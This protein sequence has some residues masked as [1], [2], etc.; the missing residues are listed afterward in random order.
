M[1][2][3]STAARLQE[4]LAGARLT[5]SISVLAELGIPDLLSTGPRSSEDLAT[6]SHTD[7]DALYR[8][9]RTLAAA[10]VLHEGD[11]HEFAL[12]E[13][14]DLLRT[15]APASLRDQAL[16]IFS[17]LF[18][19]AW[20]N[21]GHSIRTGENAFRALHGEDVWAWQARNP[22]DEARFNR[23]MAGVTAGVASGVAEAYDFG[24][25]R[26]VVDVGGG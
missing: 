16:N 21:L 14:G 4:L 8:L 11:G 5:Q 25:H 7:P 9:L 20:G 17:P 10:G 2:D 13:L 26:T 18:R 19:E 3:P 24:Q 23:G 15:D 12:T 6:A 1:A 22:A